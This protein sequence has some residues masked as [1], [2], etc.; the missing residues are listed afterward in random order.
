MTTKNS[1]K[2][3][4]GIF[5]GGKYTGTPSRPSFII[6]LQDVLY[7]DQGCGG[8]RTHPTTKSVQLN[9]SGSWEEPQGPE[10]EQANLHTESKGGNVTLGM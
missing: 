1:T 3:Y 2:L 6:H 7:P 5:Q 9:D 8:D 4:A 10:G